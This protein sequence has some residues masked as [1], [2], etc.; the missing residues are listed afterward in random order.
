MLVESLFTGAI[1]LFTL[2]CLVTDVRSRRIPNWLTVPSFVRGLVAHTVAGGL[3]GLQAS[4]GGAVTGFG[5]LFV[6]FLFG[7]GGGGD[8]KMMSA[9]GAWLGASLVLQAFLASAVVT[10]IIVL[11]ATFRAA[12]PRWS[13]TFGRLGKGAV[14]RPTRSCNP[15][16]TSSRPGR[17]VPYAV[18]LA[19][20]TWAVPAF[21]WWRNGGLFDGG[22][23]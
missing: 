20:G 17:I 21:S 22:L 6:L 3:S 16:K 8:V 14:K 4:L 13:A 12:I 2:V 18:P 7:G 1:V 5:I 15:P 23:F 19:F 11:L 9:L 10:V